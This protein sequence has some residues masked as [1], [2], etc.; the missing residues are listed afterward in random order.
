MVARAWHDDKELEICTAG[1][2]FELGC[3][4]LIRVQ[5]KQGFT[6]LSGPAKY[7]FREGGILESKIKKHGTWQSTLNETPYWKNKH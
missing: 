2:E 1:L 3:A 4:S 5:E 7:I 6:H